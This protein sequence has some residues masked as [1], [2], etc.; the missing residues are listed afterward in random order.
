MQEWKCT[1]CGCVYNWNEPVMVRGRPYCTGCSDDPPILTGSTTQRP[2][3]APWCIV[4]F[5]L[6][7]LVGKWLFS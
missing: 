4:F 6:G 1:T 3:T 7:L 2:G 5:F